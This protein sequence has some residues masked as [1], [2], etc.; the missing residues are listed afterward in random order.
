MYQ[1]LLSRPDPKYL[2]TTKVKFQP[3]L[4]IF[5]ITFRLKHSS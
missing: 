4:K 1:I 3:Q 5:L 2:F